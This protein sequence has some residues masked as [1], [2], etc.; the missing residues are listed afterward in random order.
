MTP[1]LL[2]CFLKGINAKSIL[3]TSNFPKLET[4]PSFYYFG[5]GLVIGGIYIYI[6]IYL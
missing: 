5:E 3:P 4:D 6:Y 2:N 1:S